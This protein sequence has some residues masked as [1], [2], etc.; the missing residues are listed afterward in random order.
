[1]ELLPPVSDTG[2]SILLVFIFG[3]FS[4]PGETHTTQTTVG[5]NSTWAEV[6]PWVR[7]GGGHGPLS[8]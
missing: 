7:F 2:G 5:V 1:L 4:V 6:S 3:G 8:V